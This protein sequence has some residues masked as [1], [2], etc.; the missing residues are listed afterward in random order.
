MT[1]TNQPGTRDAYGALL[2][3]SLQMGPVALTVTQLDRSVE[4]YR[5]AL[6]LRVHRHDAT[7]A[8]L[9]DGVTTSV[10]LHESPVARPPGRTAGLYHVALL[11]PSRAALAEA[12][13]RLA[14]TRT[15]IQGASDHGTHEAIY[16]P[17]PDG[18]GL[19]LAADRERTLWP[20]PE[21][22]FSSGGPRPLDFRSLLSALP[23]PP[24]PAVAAGLKV[25][26]VHLHVG[27]V[28]RGLAFYRDAIGF[29]VWAT[30]PSAAFVAAGG[31]HHHLAFNTWRGEGVPAQPTDV[32]GLRHWT[33]AVPDPDE[34]RARLDDHA[35]RDLDDGF[36]VADP[37]GIEL[38]VRTLQA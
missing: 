12:A 35:V 14:D 32:V 24:G 19:E 16:L 5:T 20:T 36:A 25:G 10:V 13:Q 28:E 27:D 26:H 15:P 8:E 21:Q 6:G 29:G 3:D 33:I 37:W 1:T 38:Q 31:Y 7:E 23:A 17:D 18:L 9:G 4:W 11:Y 22:E 2:P 30:L 34:V